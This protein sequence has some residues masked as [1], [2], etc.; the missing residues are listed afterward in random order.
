MGF[1]RNIQTEKYDREYTD[2]ALLRRI[3]SYFRPRRGR[4]ALIAFLLFLLSL[5]FAAAPVL[6][7][8]GVDRMGQR[9]DAWFLALLVG[10]VLALG[11]LAWLTNWAQRRLTTIIIGDVVLEM[12]HD[13][14]QAAMS[15][16]LSFYDE[17][18]SGRIVSRI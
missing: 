14:F 17:Y 18:Q 9:G 13:A 6:M 10:G 4:L 15:H 16:D 2:R 12:R 7:A 8:R 3:W 11:I 1:M 5:F